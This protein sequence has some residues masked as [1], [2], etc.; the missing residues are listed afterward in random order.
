MESM[1]EDEDG[2]GVFKIKEFIYINYFG[3]IQKILGRIG[4]NLKT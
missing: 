4:L 2:I 3:T 1:R